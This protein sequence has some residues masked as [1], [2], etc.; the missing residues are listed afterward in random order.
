MSTL[1]LAILLSQSSVSVNGLR[2]HL[3]SLSSGL[4]L[5]ESGFE[6]LNGAKS[7]E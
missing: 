5:G 1:W 2:F 4:P 7:P 6:E 3:L